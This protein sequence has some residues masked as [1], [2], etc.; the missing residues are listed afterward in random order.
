MELSNKDVKII[1]DTGNR[2]EEF[3]DLKNG[4]IRL[5]NVNGYCFF[6]NHLDKKCKIYDKR[7]IGCYVY[8]VVY[9]ENEFAVID[10]LCPMGYTVSEQEF[11]K[12]EKILEK[13]LKKLDN[14]VQNRRE[15]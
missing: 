12:K 4:V 11:M 14:E 3:A 5:K 7:P 10:E 6:Y 15:L 9:L 13:F 1:L 8:P 2:F